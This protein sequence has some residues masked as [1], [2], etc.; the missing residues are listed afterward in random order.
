VV[1]PTGAVWLG[2][3]VGCARCHNHKFDQISQ[4]E[5]Y[6]L[7]AFFNN[8]DETNT[9]VPTSLEAMEQYIKLKAG[10]DARVRAMEARLA[11]AKELIHDAVPAWEE[12]TTRRIRQDEAT[13]YK[14][15]P[16]DRR[17]DRDAPSRRARS[18]CDSSSTRSRRLRRGARAI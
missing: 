7:F 11:A 12:E 9:E 16:L 6:R 5:Y 17:G 15:H 10:H 1:E 2:L 18:M 13:G 4:E 3:T 8:G 14:T